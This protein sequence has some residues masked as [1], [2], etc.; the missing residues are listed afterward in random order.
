ML[1]NGDIAVRTAIPRST[2]SRLTR[3]L[4]V[5]GYLR[6]LPRLEKYELGPGILALG[7]HRLAASGVREVARPH[8]QAPADPPALALA[9]GVA[10]RPTMLH[11]AVRTRTRPKNPRPAA[12]PRGP[13]PPPPLGTAHLPLPP[14][15]PRAGGAA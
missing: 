8:M 14:A 4:A 3:T 12:G 11:I 10:D 1:G 5:L 2:V 13:P 7:Y 9:L 6:Y 15:P